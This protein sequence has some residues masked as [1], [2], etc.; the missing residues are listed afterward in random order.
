[1]K[2]VALALALVLAV[3][4][5]RA[6]ADEPGR[7]EPVAP[8]SELK[9]RV[10]PLCGATALQ[11]QSWSE[12]LVEIR[13]VTSEAKSGTVTAIGSEPR[14]GGAA[15]TD[16]APFSVAAGAT[17][18]LRVPM[19]V[20]SDGDPGV[21][22]HD[23]SGRLLYE[24]HFGRNDHNRTLL[25][26]VGRATALGSPLNG[27]PVGSSNDPWARSPYSLG[28]GGPFSLAPSRTAATTIEVVQSSHDPAS[29]EPL[30]PTRAASYSRVAA[31][32]VR[33]DALVRLPLTELAALAGWALAG[34]TIAVVVARP[35]DL[36]H[37]TLASL[38]G[39]EAH[40]SE[41]L[42]ETTRPIALTMPPSSPSYGT[43]VQP[44]D[45]AVPD[46][47]RP[48]LSGYTGGNLAASSYGASASYGLGEVHLLAFDPQTRPG[49]D[50]AWA[51]VRMIDL[52]RRA[53]ERQ[54]SLM[55]RLGAEQRYTD[56]V[57]RY[58]DPNESSRLA[59]V[60]AA[61][62]LCV[63]AAAAGPIN[64]SFWRRQQ[65]PLSALPTMAALSLATFA[66][67]VVIGVSAKGCTGRSRHLTVIEAGAGMKLGAAWRWRGFFVPS[68]R[69]IAVR[70]SHSGAVLGGAP[71]E[72]REQVSDSLLFDREGLRLIDV[73]LRPWQTHV[74]RE[75]GFSDLGDGIALL[76]IS[77]TET[78]IINRTGRALR[79]LTLWQPPATLFL[80]RLESGASA[81]TSDFA[82][83]TALSSRAR[84][85]SRVLEFMPEHIATEADGASRNVTKAWGAVKAAV[86]GDEWF[87]SDVPV[88]LAQIEGGEGDRSDTNLR[89]DHDRVLV[90]VVGYGGAP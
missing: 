41:L 83:T 35:E 66:G 58:L 27:V 62:L 61:L 43:R 49:V 87:P 37:P 82:P 78:K 7:Q 85:S 25:F 4:S 29:G 59:I 34:G 31:V 32:L 89:L 5:K 46:E 9:L 28:W 55:F 45:T 26:N 63:Y 13:N 75:D 33:S 74:V 54:Q 11:Q 23:T 65:R 50:T 60:I 39:G 68:A 20:G 6:R 67:I 22:V 42:A 24:E 71:E 17:V 30:L 88:L 2:T 1:V 80:A 77:P 48:L 16:R 15:N 70:A 53:N 64:F 8:A 36:R 44:S 18:H 38:V 40:K 47:L 14:Q 19:R 90:R 3:W 72:Y 21:R 79:A 56:L 10:T 81:V 69:S 73:E 86:P 52:L 76:R 84:G 57:R 51:Q 12:I